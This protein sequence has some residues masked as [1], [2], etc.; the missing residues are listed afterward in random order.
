MMGTQGAK[1]AMVMVA[2]ALLCGLAAP[3]RADVRLPRV[4][5]SHMVLQCGAGPSRARQ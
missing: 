1:R 2:A 4:I 3:A 5:G